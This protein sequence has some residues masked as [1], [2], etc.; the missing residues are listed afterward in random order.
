MLTIV[1]NCWAVIYCRERLKNGGRKF[2][3]VWL[4]FLFWMH[5]CSLWIWTQSTKRSSM[6]TYIL[7]NPLFTNWFRVYSMKDSTLTMKQKLKRAREAGQLIAN[8]YSGN[9]FQWVFNQSARLVQLPGTKQM[10][11]GSKTEWKYQTFAN[12]AI[13]QYVK[14]VLLSFISNLFLSISIGL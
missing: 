2:L 1:I 5:L 6:P 14:G 12:S 3:S 13:Y 11:K 10:M 9:I 7:E 8:V 4:R